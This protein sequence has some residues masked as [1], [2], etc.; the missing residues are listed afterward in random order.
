[1]R[2]CLMLRVYHDLR[3]REIAG[4]MRL[5]AET[6]K[7]HLFQARKRLQSELGPYFAGSLSRLDERTP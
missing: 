2:K 5:S 6:V 4:V 3:Y 7:V 1:M